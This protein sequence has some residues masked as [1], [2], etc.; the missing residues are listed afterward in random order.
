MRDVIGFTLLA[1]MFFGVLI[2]LLPRAID[3][4]MEFREQRNALYVRQ[5]GEM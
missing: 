3:G 4:E 5:M 2:A 1:L